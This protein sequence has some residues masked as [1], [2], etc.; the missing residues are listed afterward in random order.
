MNEMDSHFIQFYGR[1]VSSGDI[2][3][4]KSLILSSA[5]CLPSIVSYLFSGLIV[6]S[7]LAI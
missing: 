1:Q 4:V 7:F 3:Q 6:F 5:L 2:A